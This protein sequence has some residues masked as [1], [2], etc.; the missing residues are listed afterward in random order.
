MSTRMSLF[1]FPQEYRP[2]H[3]SIVNILGES[4]LLPLGRVCLNLQDFTLTGAFPLETQANELYSL[5]SL[6]NTEAW[7]ERLETA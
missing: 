1:L 6:L 3:L 7:L 2:I 4:F 5:P